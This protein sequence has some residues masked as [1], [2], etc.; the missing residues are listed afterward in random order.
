MS[1]V[2]NSETIVKLMETKWT[3]QTGLGGFHFGWPQ[4]VDEIHS[5]KLPLMVMNP[6]MMTIST[7]SYNSNTILADSNWTFTV[8]QL[9]NTNTRD[10]L[11]ILELWDTLEDKVLKW[12]NSWW[13]DF[14]TQGNDFVLTAPIQITRT[15]EASNDRLL[16]LKVTFSFN[17]YRYCNPRV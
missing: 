6:P 15:K 17:F 9:N 12:F 7:K 10:D 14:Q 3:N 1:A 11:I 8:Y 13:L 16:A 5:K 4:E 2:I